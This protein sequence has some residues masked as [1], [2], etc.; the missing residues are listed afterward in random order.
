MGGAQSVP[1]ADGAAKGVKQD[2]QGSGQ[3]CPVRHTKA[4]Q[5]SEECPVK[6]ASG[7]LARYRNKD[8]YNVYSQ[9]I[10]PTNNMPANPN[11]QPAPGQTVELDTSRVS[12]T[13]PKGG[14]DGTWTYPS[15][16]MFY[17]AIVRKG[18]KGA[19][20]EEDMEMVVSIHN[21][22]NE[23]TWNK[24]MAWEAFHLDEAADEKG[25]A[26]RLLRFLGRPDELSPLARLKG[27]FGHPEPFDRHDWVV[28][29]G[30]KEIRYII[31]YYHDVS[32]A[33]MDKKPSLRD[34]ESIQSIVLE[35]RPALDSLEAIVDRYVRMPIAAVQ[36]TAR[37][38]A[39]PFFASSSMIEA[40]RLEKAELA[41]A[42]AEAAAAEEERRSGS[43]RRLPAPI[44]QSCGQLMN[45]VQNCKGQE[46][47]TERLVGF[48]LCSAR[49]A[50]PDLAKAF[51]QVYA[52]GD[53]DKMQAS[54]TE[55][56]NCTAAW[57]K[58]YDAAAKAS[59]TA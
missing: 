41:R 12:S 36:G 37:Y 59:G 53:Q 5:D 51:E 21:N 26:P 17:N 28:D 45:L 49:I 3:G 42:E 14:T 2:K 40:D 46:E 10:D 57:L 30:G 7:M 24:V 58:K 20:R 43:G 39:P 16:Q 1:K 11:Q 50:C 4:A 18:K 23:R 54:Y 6:N 32:R 9:K 47:C 55:M 38:T 15:P 44:A 29:R 33:H 56:S 52:A 48:Q 27:L 35:V 31:D 13:I 8:V 19:T 34:E 25:T 22:M